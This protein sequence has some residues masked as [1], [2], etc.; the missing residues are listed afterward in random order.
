[1]VEQKRN[2]N[3]LTE[4][5][6]RAR[7]GHTRGLVRQPEYLIILLLMT[8]KLK[9]LIALSLIVSSAFGTTLQVNTFAKLDCILLRQSLFSYWDIILGMLILFILIPFIYIGYLKRLTIPEKNELYHFPGEYDADKANDIIAYVE[10]LENLF[11]KRFSNFK[12]LLVKFEKD[13]AEDKRMYVE[14]I[15]SI[16]FC[17]KLNGQSRWRVFWNISDRFL[18]FM[19]FMLPITGVIIVIISEIYFDFTGLVFSLIATIFSLPFILIIFSS[20]LKMSQYIFRKKGTTQPALSLAY[21]ALDA[22]INSHV[23]RAYD[24]KTGTYY[25]YTTIHKY[26][27]LVNENFKFSSYHILTSGEILGDLSKQALGEK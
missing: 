19:I 23:S 27:D 20:F 9:L 1:M 8:N 25:Y 15:E 3:S 18:K 24:K 13:P 12:N 14:A 4:K 5:Q 16:I 2:S 22:L 21:F 17:I 10:K 7:H 26:N 6:D 11:G